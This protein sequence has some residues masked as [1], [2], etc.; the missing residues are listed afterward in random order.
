VKTA[1]YPGNDPF[2]RRGVGHVGGDG[3][4]SELAGGLIEGRRV[5]GSYRYSQPRGT[6][7]CSDVVPKAAAASGNERDHPAELTARG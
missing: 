5:A 1:I 6:K 3:K 2:H 7:S 4:S